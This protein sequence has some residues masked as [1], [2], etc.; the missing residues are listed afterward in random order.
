MILI[1]EQIMDSEEHKG[2]F[3]KIAEYFL[4]QKVDSKKEK[5]RKIVVLLAL[6][7]FIISGCVISVNYYKTVSDKS[8]NEL[9]RKYYYE[10]SDNSQETPLP[11]DLEESVKKF[12][13]DNPTVLHNFAK[14]LEINSDTIGWIKVG[15]TGIDYPVFRGNDN[16][17]YLTHNNKQEYSRF[18]SVFVDYRTKIEQ[19]DMS[20]ISILYAH[21]MESTGEYFEKLTNFSPWETGL[22]YYTQTP[23]ID[24]DTLYEQSKWK[25]FAV[26]YCTTDSRYGE[27]FNYLDKIDFEG[28][29]DFYQYM[30]DVMDRSLIYTDVDVKY[31]DKFLILSTCYFPIKSY[32]N[33]RILIYARKVR[34]GESDLVNTDKAYQN[35]S[36]KLF[37]YYYNYYGG[38]WQG[39][40][41]DHSKLDGYD[42]WLNHP[43]TSA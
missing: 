42:E 3:K 31:G 41:W 26:V 37:W 23:V 17:F 18:G 15:E 12:Y 14:L 24:Y 21:N 4:P 20:D 40:Q 32:V 2:F 6:I 36:P 22:D 28:E 5:A 30:S 9:L 38:S 19:D 8:S 43:D 29:D 11:D 16:Q 10:E 7:I 1:N 33:G 25:I 27:V 34:E 13:E 39:S 35:P